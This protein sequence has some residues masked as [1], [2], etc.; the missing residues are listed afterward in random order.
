[1]MATT[2][3]ISKNKLIVVAGMHRSGTS[4]IAR[5][6]QVLGIPLGQNLLS[7][8][9]D[10]PTGFWEDRDVVDINDTLL[11]NV[12]EQYDSLGPLPEIDVADES[13][14][15][16]FLQAIQLIAERMAENNGIW[17]V[18]DPRL[19]RLLPFWKQVFRHCNVEVCYILA[20]RNPLSVIDSLAKRNGFEPEKSYMLWLVHV[21]NSLSDTSN[22]NRIIVD[23]DKLMQQ[24]ERELKRMAMAC[25][26]SFN[27]EEFNLYKT[28]FL[29]VDLQHTLY[30]AQALN[31]GNRL[32][33]LATD[34]YQTLLDLSVTNQMDE[35]TLQ[36]KTA[37]WEAQ[38]ESLNPAL[39]LTDKLFRTIATL[40]E[41]V[42]YLQQKLL[43]SLQ[44]PTEIPEIEAPIPLVKYT[45]QVDSHHYLQFSYNKK[46]RFCSY[47]HQIEEVRKL[48]PE[49]ILEIGMGNGFVAWFLQ[50]AGLEVTT[51]DIDPDLKPTI[52]GSVVDIPLPDDSFDLVMCCQLLE[53]LPYDNFVPA[54]LQLHRVAKKHVVL[55]LPDM[56]PVHRVHIE[57]PIGKARFF[58]PKLF[59]KP[60]DW[61][62]DGQ[63]HWNINNLGYPTTRIINDIMSTNFKIVSHFRVPENPGHHFFILN[64]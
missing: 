47:W 36:Q 58:Y 9:F 62:F 15:P 30:S 27:P 46:G 25:H 32:P 18:K 34:I 57:T 48:N 7:A 42:E 5:G 4:A 14:R 3:S 44:P 43:I 59:S 17:G 35:A 39:Q 61:K 13:I 6:L 56:K 53:H 37:F 23:Y 31:H 12:G 55:S 45:K 63:H 16:L 19:S 8:Q 2:P 11:S 41:A 64:K 50:N 38:L 51:M 60:I 21:I 1:M 24:P 26:L 29:D 52:V 10:N 40:N 33:R 22:C 20:I 28:A 54:L 49:N